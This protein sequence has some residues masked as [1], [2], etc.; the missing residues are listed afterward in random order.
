[1]KHFKERII[2][3]L[4]VLMGLAVGIFMIQNVLAQQVGGAGSRNPIHGSVDLYSEADLPPLVGGAHEL[5]AGTEYRIMQ[6]FSIVNPISFPDGLAKVKAIAFAQMTYTGTGALIT[7]LSVPANSFLAID[8]A[9]ISAP[10]GSFFDIDGDPSGFLLIDSS[11]VINA[12]EIGTIRNIGVTIF[13]GNLIGYGDGL[14]Y[15]DLSA[16]TF[17]RLQVFGSQN[18]QRL[19]YDAQTANFTLDGIATGATSGA[20]GTIEIDR[21]SGATG[22]IVLSGVSGTFQDDEIITDAVTGS[23]TVNG[24]LQNTVLMTLEGDHGSRQ[25]SSNFFLPESNETLFDIKQSSTTTSHLV[26]GNAFNL[27]NGG[28]IFT[29][30]SKDQT[31]PQADWAANSNVPDSDGD[32]GSPFT[33]ILDANNAL[34]PS[35]NPAG[36]FSRNGHP[37]IVF[38]D[39]TA[40]NVIFTNSVGSGYSGDDITVNIDWVAE[41]AITGGVT[42]GVSFEANAEGGNDIDSDSFA[43]QQTGN[44]DTNATSGIITTTSITLTQAQADSIAAGDYFR[45]EVERVVSDGDD[46]MVGDAQILSITITQ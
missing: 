27:A 10:N 40:E 45:M 38:D 36:A 43:T 23:A 44:S 3:G 14:V 32:G 41:S 29:S 30:T 21:D 24:V 18:W 6:D 28:Q 4:F 17:S 42:W 35:S 25:V 9:N 16:F 31:D 39:T 2:G 34:Y 46:D 22:Q 11:I 26:V 7:D 15:E 20:T 13:F 1:M 8:Y 12:K 37:I 5:D 19:D 33:K